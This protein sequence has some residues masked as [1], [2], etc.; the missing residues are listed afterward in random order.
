ML[1]ETVATASS[2]DDQVARQPEK[3]VAYI[4]LSLGQQDEVGTITTRDFD[5]VTVGCG[6]QSLRVAAKFR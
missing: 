3:L 2:G 1:S 6:E 5:T 4:C